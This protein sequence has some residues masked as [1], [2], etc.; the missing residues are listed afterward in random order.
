MLNY[1]EEELK[2]RKKCLHP[3]EAFEFVDN[4]KSENEE[5]NIDENEEDSIDENENEDEKSKKMICTQYSG[6]SR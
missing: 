4:K 6:H 3:E 1:T 5:D 2:L